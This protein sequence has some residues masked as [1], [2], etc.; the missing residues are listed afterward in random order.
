MRPA[1]A[2]FLTLC[3]AAPARA[4][5]DVTT[6]P[7]RT[8]TYRITISGEA[9]ADYV[10]RSAGLTDLRGSFAAPAGSTSVNRMEGQASLRLTLD[11]YDDIRFGMLIRNERV[12]VPSTPMG[13]DGLAPAIRELWLEWSAIWRPELTV[14]AGAQPFAFDVRGRG[15]SFFFEPSR[16]EPYGTD[17]NSLTPDSSPRESQPVGV[18]GRWT[19]EGYEA[20]LA[21]LPAI[22]E[23]GPSSE[24][25]AAYALTFLYNLGQRSR[26]GG[27]AAIT[28][29]PGDRTKLLTVGGGLTYHELY[30]GLELYGELYFQTGSTGDVIVSGAHRDLQAKGLGFQLGGRYGDAEAGW[31]VELNFTQLSGDDDV[32]DDEESRFL[33]YESI[34]DLLIW[35]D[36]TYG[37]DLDNNYSAIKISGG[38]APMSGVEVKAVL[39]LVSVLEDAPFNPVLP[40]R[41]G[42]SATELDLVATWDFAPQARVYA[43]VGILTGSDLF[44]RFTADT[45][46]SAQVFVL[47]STLR[48]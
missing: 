42:G 14:R 35:E 17:V 33:S 4:Q 43:M 32:N 27:I 40:N 22:R 36:A 8:E 10:W 48:W 34:A 47:G 26:A 2:L 20:A 5:V 13:A 38:L 16:A 18:V 30:P 46:S 19:T 1:T 39:G 41:E 21:L 23:G 11:T 6:S 24:D 31:W 44:E 29:S 3:T 12:P 7:E 45:E 37:V 15:S 25:H 9:T 28:S